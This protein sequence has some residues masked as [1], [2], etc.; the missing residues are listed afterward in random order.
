MFK[1]NKQGQL[2]YKQDGKIRGFIVALENNRFAYSFGKP[3]QSQYISF[4]C[5]DLK[6]AQD[7]F[8]SII[9]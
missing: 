4:E 5:S 8:L 9:R 6:A 2:V 7:T 1:E 3:S